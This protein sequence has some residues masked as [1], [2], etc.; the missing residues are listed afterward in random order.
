MV[1]DRT[2][3]QLVPSHC[4]KEILEDEP[5]EYETYS[6][7]IPVH[8]LYSL[9][10]EESGE[11]YERQLIGW[12]I[13]TAGIIVAV[14]EEAGDGRLAV[15]RDDDYLFSF[16]EADRERVY[17]ENTPPAASMAD[18]LAAYSELTI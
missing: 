10:R 15:S 11:L 9:H 1:Q 12:G 7:L 5:C 4:I 2:G 18:M 3:L 17:A 14:A 16:R 13:T 6:Q 8:D